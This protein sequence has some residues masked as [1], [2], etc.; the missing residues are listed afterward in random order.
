MNAYHR[1]MSF[2]VNNPFIIKPGTDEVNSCE[3]PSNVSPPWKRWKIVNHLGL[4]DS[5][6]NFISCFGMSLR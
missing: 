5:L 4:M 3:G 2:N 6:F 1:D